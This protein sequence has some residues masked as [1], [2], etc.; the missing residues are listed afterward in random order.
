MPPPALAYLL[1]GLIIA[2]LVA[3]PATCYLARLFARYFPRMDYALLLR[4]II[5]GLII[6]VFLFTGPLGL[7]VLAISTAVGLLAPQAG[8]RRSHAMGVLLVPIMVCFGLG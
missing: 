3:F 8:V 6:L 1:M 5:V 7:L 2:T 4:S